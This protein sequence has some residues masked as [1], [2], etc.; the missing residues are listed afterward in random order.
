MFTVTLEVDC[1]ELGRLLLRYALVGLRWEWPQDDCGY[2]GGW[3]ADDVRL[4]DAWL[5]GARFPLE[6]LQAPPF[7]DRLPG[8]EAD[9]WQEWLRV[10]E[11]GP[12]ALRDD[13]HWEDVA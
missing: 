8:W 9:A 2:R 10:A 7:A 6:V 13:W 5:D 11:D 3:D 4:V 12:G 1:G